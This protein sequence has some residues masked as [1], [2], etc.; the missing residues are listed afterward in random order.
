MP[1]VRRVSGT[2]TGAAD[3]APIPGVS[4]SVKGTTLGTITDNDGKYSLDVP[5][6]VTSLVFSFI[7][8]K[9]LEAPITGSTL[10]VV[11]ESDLQEIGE[12]VAIG[13][14]V[15]RKGSITGSVGTVEAEKMEQVPVVSFDNALQGQVAGLT[16]TSSS[17]RPGAATTVRIR[18]IS[19]INAGN[20]PLYIMDGIEISAGEFYN[21]NQ[22]DIEQIS[23]LKD[24]SAA[25]I[26]GSRAANGVVII[27]TKRGKTNEE[28]E[29]TFRAM[30]GISI[31]KDEKID[32]MTTKEN[33]IM[34]NILG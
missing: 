33:W 12:I 34:K 5:N 23:V 2:V 9:S 31:L 11:L 16:V 22:N 28:T 6:D 4:V 25:S 30:S 32:F 7:G 18:G 19:S 13:Y 27:T 29:V 8:M 21:L 10:D 1:R 17:G 24:A 14:G 3:N 20:N 15:K 26:Y